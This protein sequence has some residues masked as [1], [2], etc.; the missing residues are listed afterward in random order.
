[1]SK[2]KL[3][4]KMRLYLKNL[5]KKEKET[6]EQKLKNHLLSEQMWKN[7]HT[8]GIT[9]S[10]KEEWN[11]R[12]IIRRA[13]EQGKEVCIPKCD[14][15]ERHMQFYQFTSFNQLET[16]YYN[17]LEPI[18]EETTKIAKDQID[19]LVVPGLVFDNRGY[20]IGFGGGFYDRF[21]KKFPNITVSLL[22]SQQLVE[23][24]PQESFDIPVQHLI[25]ETGKVK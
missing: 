11:T 25:T 15:K 23:K 18:P 2:N 20:R 3:R 13:W 22:T 19:L 9:I 6:I 21:L 24:I 14:P 4:K 5:P 8:I 12:E 10:Q 17:L 16:V 7:A 1:M